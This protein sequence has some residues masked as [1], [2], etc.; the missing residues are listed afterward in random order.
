MG[1]TGRRIGGV[2]ALSLAAAMLTVPPA[3]ATH[4]VLGGGS[5][6]G[7]GPI[8][9]PAAG[10]LGKGTVALNFQVDY[11][12]FDTFSDRELLGFAA[13]DR[14]IHNL[15]SV[16]TYSVSASY[17]AG[18]FAT[19]HVA[20]PYVVRRGIE[21]SEPPDEIHSHGDASGLGD[22]SA[23]AH[24]RLFGSEAWGIEVTGIVALKVPTGQ[25]R[26][27]DDAGNR[28]DAEFQPGSGSWDP[29]VGLAV[30]EAYGP[31]AL[32]GAVRYTWVTEGVLDTDLGDRFNYDLAFV[33]RV[34]PPVRVDLVLEANGLWQDRERRAGEEDPDSGGQVLLVSPGLRWRMHPRANA[35]VS[36]GLPVFQDLN[37]DQNEVRF[38][39]L[40]GVGGAF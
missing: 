36:A 6:K 32:H 9:T 33:Y 19:F 1:R 24:V 12:A 35:Y 17:G 11:Q 30:S 16:T 34:P 23:H 27:R 7:A 14:E 8:V 38:R 21:E 20:V 28:F 3:G 5:G 37:G 22:A 31:F 2:A 39:V 10:N 15:E 13:E 40:A 4:P 26:V 25:T 18:R 29:T